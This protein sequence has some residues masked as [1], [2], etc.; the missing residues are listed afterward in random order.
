MFLGGGGVSEFIGA[1]DEV[2]IEQNCWRRGNAIPRLAIE[3]PV[4]PK[5]GRSPILPNPK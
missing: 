1:F 4:P 3:V 5:S 2:K